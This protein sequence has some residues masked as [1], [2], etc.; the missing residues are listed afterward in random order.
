MTRCLELQLLPAKLGARRLKGQR[1][2]RW[3][4]VNV[5]IIVIASG[6]VVGIMVQGR[7][8]PMVKE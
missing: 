5:C 1:E 8:W 3:Q 6:C 2:H 4:C 7:Y